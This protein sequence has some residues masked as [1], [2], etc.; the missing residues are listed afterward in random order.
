MLI[1]QYFNARVPSS[2]G[3]REILLEYEK[4]ANWLTRGPT[5]VNRVQ[6]CITAMMDPGRMPCHPLDLVSHYGIAV[7]TSPDFVEG[8]SSGSTIRQVVPY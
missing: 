1:H 3:R 2:Q 6:A 5:L 7:K 4:H 8:S